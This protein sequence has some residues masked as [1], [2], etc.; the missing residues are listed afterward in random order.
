MAGISLPYV[1]VDLSYSLMWVSSI[2][3]TISSTLRSLLAYRPG[4][5]GL[6]HLVAWKPQCFWSSLAYQARVEELDSKLPSR[7]AKLRST[8]KVEVLA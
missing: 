3:P 8:H 5:T 6:A 4:A 2:A 7:T 1:P